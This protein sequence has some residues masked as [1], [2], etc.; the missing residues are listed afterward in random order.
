MYCPSCKQEVKIHNNSCEQCNAEFP[1]ISEVKRLE[2]MIKARETSKLRA[3]ST[4]FKDYRNAKKTG[5]PIPF[6]SIKGL[7]NA[8]LFRS[9]MIIFAIGGIVTSGI[10]IAQ[11][12]LLKNQEAI[13]KQQTDLMQKE[14]NLE[15]YN[16]LK[17][18]KGYLAKTPVDTNGDPLTLYL[19]KE[20]Q[21]RSWPIISDSD[22]ETISYLSSYARKKDLNDILYSFLNEKD[23]VSLSVGAFFTII[24]LAKKTNRDTI[25]DF[26]KYDI[27]FSKADL[28]RRTISNV[29]LKKAKFKEAF[30]FET[31][32]DSVHFAEEVSFDESVFCGASIKNCYFKGKLSFDAT[33]FLSNT[34]FES[35]TFSDATDFF[36]CIFEQV[37]FINNLS[38]ENVKFHT[39]QFWG[40]QTMFKKED[41]ELRDSSRFSSSYVYLNDRDNSIFDKMKIKKTLLP[42]KEYNSAFKKEHG[43]LCNY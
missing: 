19:D 6:E 31:R 33:K 28:S 15:F 23:N 11:L 30:F 40:N 21:I 8:W 41:K 25:L 2:G 4:F 7:L 3:A 10:A 42:D 14:N 22:I 35:N 17:E 32:F 38:F 1:W 29:I 16:Y 24:Q 43:T 34:F 5:D 39:C 18:I 20:D 26:T 13:L 37:K 36:N 12:Y 9:G 27:N